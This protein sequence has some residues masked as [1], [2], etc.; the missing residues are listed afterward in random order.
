MTEIVVDLAD[1]KTRQL[2]SA[3]GELVERLPEQWVLIGGLMV[4][5]HM[6][7]HGVTDVRL[8]HDVDVLGQA[9]PPGALSL[10]DAALRDDDFKVVG[11]DLD[12]YAHRYERDGLI[13]DVLAPE[14][15]EPPPSLG[16]GRKAIGV[17]GGT[18]A[19]DRSEIVTVIVEGSAFQLRRPT[20]LGAV[21]IKARSLMVH[22]D[23]ESQREDL[24][25]LLA[26]LED[27]RETAHGLRKTERKWLRVAE[28]RLQLSALSSL[29]AA[30]MRRAEL[31]YRLLV[32]EP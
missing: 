10:I 31:A 18:Q 2:W 13:V 4:Q 17:P 29:E 16:A 1:E 9:R 25:R 15:I 7:E 30:T 23:P 6:I 11:L 19:L 32:R 3:V 24:L 26:L 12:G 5:L 8:T 27:P 20:L 28:Q 14:G 21:L 22:S